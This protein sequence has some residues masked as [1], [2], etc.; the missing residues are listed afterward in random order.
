MEALLNTQKEA[1]AGLQNQINNY[2]KAGK[3]RKSQRTYLTNRIME[4]QDWW[5]SF[6]DHNSQ[7]ESL[8]DGHE[9]QPYFVNDTF[10]Q[11]KK[12][13][14][15]HVAA[16]QAKLDTLNSE[17]P[18]IHFASLVSAQPSDEEEGPADNNENGG[19]ERATQEYIQN[20]ENAE[21]NNGMNT[22]K[23]LVGDLEDV[24]MAIRTMTVAQKSSSGFIIAQTEILK[25]T[26]A[27][28]RALFNTERGKS[29]EQIGFVDFKGLQSQYTMSYGELNDFA[30]QRKRTGENI[31]L[32]KLQI[33]NFY[34]T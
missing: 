15:E 17:V 10:E 18:N 5:T 20:P 34:G 3:D 4:L 27:D 23:L 13:Y 8:K 9:T 26:W 2:R 6:E 12:T 11:A 31:Q 14:D 32:P 25:S 28:F 7:I 1:V 30:S 16:V 24:F 19:G 21:F 29:N 22:L 33:P